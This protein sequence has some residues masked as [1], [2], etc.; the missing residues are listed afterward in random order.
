MLRCAANVRSGS[1]TVASRAIRR[2]VYPRHRKQ[3]A[4]AAVGQAAPFGIG[5]L[6]PAHAAR[7]PSFSRDLPPGQA[8]F[9]TIK[10]RREQLI[11][12]VVDF[13]HDPSRLV[14]SPPDTKP[15]VAERRLTPFSC[16]E[17]GVSESAGIGWAQG[18]RKI[19]D[20][21]SYDAA[22]PATR[23]IPAWPATTRLLS[24]GRAQIDGFGPS[25]PATSP[26]S[27]CPEFHTRTPKRGCA[28]EPLS[29]DTGPEP[30][31]RRRGPGATALG[32]RLRCFEGLCQGG[33]MGPV[34]RGRTG[35]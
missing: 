20:W 30:H 9:V 19:A 26:C 12:M 3:G 31:P 6:L 29:P 24:W 23:A 17:V 34:P 33:R 28:S 27:H 7:L 1:T 13:R 21:I 8:R 4:R 18:F 14:N 2:E 16:A 15:L 5:D 32:A 35:H 25:G 11:G 10:P 22:G